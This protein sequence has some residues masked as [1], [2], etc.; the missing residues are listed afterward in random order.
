[1][2]IRAHADTY[3]NKSERP[4][5]ALALKK[6]THWLTTSN[7]E[8]L[9]ASASKNL[10][11]LYKRKKHLPA[12][13]KYT[14]WKI[15]LTLNGFCFHK[16]SIVQPKQPQNPT[17]TWSR[18]FWRKGMLPN[19]NGIFWLKGKGLISLIST[20]IFFIQSSKKQFI[21]YHQIWHHLFGL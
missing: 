11:Y 10:L 9:V 17:K 13:D 16:G 6:V 18:W 14:K 5:D 20:V 2:T 21:D 19:N 4:V 12:L 8:M 7:Q 1:M 3:T 15:F